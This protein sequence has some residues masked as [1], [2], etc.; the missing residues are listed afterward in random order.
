MLK[1]GEFTLEHQVFHTDI[2]QKVSLLGKITE[3]PE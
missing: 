3:N 2:K 1:V